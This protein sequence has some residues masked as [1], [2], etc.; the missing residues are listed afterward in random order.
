MKFH[1]SRKL[2]ILFV[3]FLC[4]CPVANA[5][6]APINNI[7][8]AMKSGNVNKLSPY[9]GNSVDIT[10][11]QNQSTYSPVQAQM[12]LR[13]FF[14]R[15]AVRDF[16]FTHTGNA[17]NSNITF[18]VGKLTTATGVYRVYMYVKQ[19]SETSTILREIKIQK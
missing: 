14:T 1:I 13:N 6:S 4:L 2:Y 7:E 16:D 3:W 19:Q 12:V 11:N 15:N 9:F 17:P 18:C 5:Q 10:I 8:L